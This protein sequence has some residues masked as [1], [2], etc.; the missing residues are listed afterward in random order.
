MVV[1]HTGHGDHLKIVMNF[2]KHTFYRAF[3][4]NRLEKSLRRAGKTRW[5][6]IGANR[7]TDDFWTIDLREGSGEKHYQC[8]ILQLKQ[9][10]FD[11]LGRFDL[12]RMQHSFEH[13]SFEEGHMLLKRCG[14]LL[15]QGGHLLITVPDLR[16]HI[17]MYLSGYYFDSKFRKFA[18]IRVPS[19][20]PPSAYFSVHAH[21]FGYAQDILVERPGSAHKWC[22]D[23]PGLLHQVARTEMFDRIRRLA[24]WNPLAGIPFTHKKPEEDVCLHARRR[25]TADAIID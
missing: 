17:R 6:D 12:V 25:H 15:N 20:A 2:F 23:Y 8:D 16:H 22:Y 5:L 13:F 18:R 11:R 19:D 3:A 10:D 4:R 14:E 24:L 7:A 21:Q 9:V 1:A